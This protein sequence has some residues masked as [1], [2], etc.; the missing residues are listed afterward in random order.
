MLISK[1]GIDSNGWQGP[2]C[3]C[4]KR[5]VYHI[6]R[7]TVYQ[8]QVNGRHTCHTFDSQL[9]HPASGIDTRL[10]RS[11]F[12]A[13]HRNQVYLTATKSKRIE[14]RACDGRRTYQGALQ[15]LTSSHDRRYE[16]DNSGPRS[17]PT[18]RTRLASP[19]PR[20]DYYCTLTA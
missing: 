15:L 16:C 6:Y 9:H 11:A 18:Y 12:E 7:S 3:C 17:A 1:Q 14:K 19:C 4:S 10:R 8:E 20:R 5:C 2:W 13:H